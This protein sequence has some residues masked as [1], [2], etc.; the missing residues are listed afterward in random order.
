MEIN[1]TQPRQL[2]RIKPIGLRS[3]D[4]GLIYRLVGRASRRLIISRRLERIIHTD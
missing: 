3:G 2:Q 1:R 4:Q